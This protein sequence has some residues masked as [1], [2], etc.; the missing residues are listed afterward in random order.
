MMFNRFELYRFQIFCS[1]SSKT[2]SPHFNLNLV[3]LLGFLL[4]PS[5]Y[6]LHLSNF[7]IKILFHL[8]IFQATFSR[9]QNTRLN[10]HKLFN[11]LIEELIIVLPLNLTDK[12]LV[13]TFATKIGEVSILFF[14]LLALVAPS[15]F[16]F[17]NPNNFSRPRTLQNNGAP[18]AN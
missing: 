14:L 15:R 16:V 1:C 13:Q 9:I 3:I 2:L 18:S 11:N 12:S 6:T 17:N 10:N 5:S 8:N 7:L 4:I